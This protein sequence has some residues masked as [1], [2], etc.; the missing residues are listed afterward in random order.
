MAAERDLEMLDDYLANR[1][2]E[3]GRSAFEQK[4]NSDPQLKNEYI[5]QQQFI[6]GIKKAR[7]AELKAMM[8][9]IPVPTG[10]S[11]AT[12]VGAKAALWVVVAGI[13]AT[14]L[15]LYLKDN[16]DT[17]TPR[18]TV[19]TEDS[20][21]DSPATIKQPEVFPKDES[22]EVSQEPS[23][24][25]QK[26]ADAPKAVKGNDEEGAI[27]NEPKIDVFD[28]TQEADEESVSEGIRNNVL[29]EK[30]SS[31]LEVEID[32]Q[33]KKYN[34][35]YQFKDGRLMLFGPFEKNLY[36]IM[37]FFNDE[38]RTIFL[39][40]NEDYYLLKEDSNKLRPLN[41]IQDP[42]LVKKLKEYRNN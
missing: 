13:V 25:E 15:Y 1:L 11:T 22:P 27:S 36:E 42:A 4:L 6:N 26:P 3:Q 21:N 19:I 41:S 17:A 39:Y 2:D 30:Q 33:N 32:S 38:K 12:A 40:Y 9:E 35:H 8:N 24:T 18:D 10:T 31:S 5:L 23:S 28:P 14:G 20:V 37:E 34:F 29:M 16:S 7:V